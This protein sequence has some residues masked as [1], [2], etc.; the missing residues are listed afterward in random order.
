MIF[1]ASKEN[2]CRRGWHVRLEPLRATGTWPGLT[3]PTPGSHV[4]HE[5]PTVVLTL[6]RLRARRAVS[7]FRASAKV[8]RQVLR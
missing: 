2:I 3:A 8:E 6:G 7:F 4:K 5:G 1:A